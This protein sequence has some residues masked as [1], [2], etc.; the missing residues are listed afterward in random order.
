MADQF[1]VTPGKVEM[2]DI[3]AT[4]VAAHGSQRL[5]F[6]ERG[7]ATM[8]IYHVGSGAAVARVLRPA[9]TPKGTEARTFIMRVTKL[10][11]E[12]CP[13]TRIVWIVIRAC[14]N[15][16]NGRLMTTRQR[17]TNDRFSAA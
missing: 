12:R 7:F 9:R 1:C 5:A 15:S 8:H 17:R 3:D 11:Q 6:C 14:P 4:F 2:F 16:N 10:L 13:N